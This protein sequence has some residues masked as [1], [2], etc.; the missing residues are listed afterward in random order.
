MDNYEQLGNEQILT[1][2]SKGFE[3]VASRSTELLP[4]DDAG[5]REIRKQDIGLKIWGRL[6][7]KEDI[8]DL[9][10]GIVFGGI[11][12]D[13][14]RYCA[15]MG[16]FL[17]YKPLDGIWVP[18]RDNVGIDSYIKEACEGMV[19]GAA[20]TNQNADTIKEANKYRDRRAR[21]R[22]VRDLRCEVTVLGDDLDQHPSL[23][24]CRNG[25]I[26]LANNGYLDHSP[27]Y[28]MT[29][30]LGVSYYQ[31]TDSSDPYGEWGRFLESIFPGEPEK[32]D[33]LQRVL[34]AALAGDISLHRFHILYGASTRNGKSTF[35]DT[36]SAVFGD[37]AV[38]VDPSTLASRQRYDSDGSKASPDIA[39]LRGARLAVVSEPPKGMY[40]NGSLIKRL[41]AGSMMTARLL[42]QDNFDFHPRAAFLIDT[43]YLP[44][45]TDMTVFTSDRA[46]VVEF[47]RHFELHE[48][49]EHLLD[50]LTS[51]EG[52]QN[53]LRWLVDGLE[54]FRR[55]GASVPD[56]I[57]LA[58][59]RY[60]LESDRLGKFIEECLTISEDGGVTG[61]ELYVR[62][63]EWCKESGIMA[64]NKTAVL[65]E[66]RTRGMLK[67]SA[68]VG[69]RTQ[70]NV[71]VGYSLLP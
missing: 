65:D 38:A 31:P 64:E 56:C 41:S 15:D 7:G 11:C 25:V 33:Y 20:A 68:R 49:D 5:K 4:D 48:R 21:D 37:Y 45:V 71:I 16:T 28:L 19:W 24:C 18:D 29:K 30:V 61:K 34:G 58:T 17:I 66:F 50:R 40:L 53:V 42:R 12:S 13:R 36:L 63:S 10:L 43:N 14:I 44:H 52:K 6:N 70:S 39:R 59:E 23:I 69:G 55:D 67:N 35:C 51:E 46:V 27:D 1:L 2:L 62:Y 9:N 8:N 22:L 54:K 32:A 47:N 57:R 26:N 3:A 60:A